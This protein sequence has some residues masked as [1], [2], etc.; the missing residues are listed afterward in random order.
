MK[1]LV[2][3]LGILV[4]ILGLS[5][6]GLV[7]RGEKTNE[8]KKEEIILDGELVVPEAEPIIPDDEPIIPDDIELE[9]FEDELEDLGEEINQL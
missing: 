9:E 6:C 1:K 3:I 8:I 4:F 7:E 2:L 5:G